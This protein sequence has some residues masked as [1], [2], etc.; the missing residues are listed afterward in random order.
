MALGALIGGGLAIAGG[1]GSAISGNKKIK[2]QEESQMRLNEQSAKLNFDYGEQAADAAHQRSLGLL[3]AET[4]ANSYEAQ[5][6]D[7]KAA[8]LSPG[9]LYGGGGAGGV[10]GSAGGGAM[11]Q[12]SGR[13]SAD[14]PNYLEVEALKQQSKLANAEIQ[15]VINESKKTKAEKE[16]IE[17]E[18]RLNDENR[19]TSE[20]LTPL[21]GALMKE[22]GIS[23]WIDNL[24]KEY[25]NTRGENHKAGLDREHKEYGTQSILAEGYFGERT[26]MEIARAISET[27]GINIANELN[28][29][30]KKGYWQELLNATIQAE[31]SKQT[32]END[33]VKAKAVKLASE[34]STGEYTNW[35]TWT[36]AASDAIGAIGNIFKI[37]P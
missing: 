2:K 30:R 18:T 33:K 13:Q 34:W 36:Q 25:E 6:A 15:R 16:N 10:G 1:I 8:G 24:R 32:A 26:A 35:K 23:I 31:A 14:A 29:E 17:S 3:N 4:E 27:E 5:L 19:M 28:T 37:A 22:Q 11:G 7:A 12:G 21:Q 20:E 9:L